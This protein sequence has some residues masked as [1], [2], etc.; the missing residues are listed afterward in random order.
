MTLEN[1]KNS[2]NRSR[3]LIATGIYPPDIG[4]PATYLPQFISFLES[5]DYNVKVVTFSDISNNDSKVFRISRKSNIIIRFLKYSFCLW[6]ESKDVDLI[7]LHDVSLVGI[8]LLLINFFKKKKYIIRIGGDN[9]WEQAYQKRLTKDKYFVFHSKSLPSLGLR[10]KKN[11]LKKLINDSKRV[12]V[13]SNFL[14]KA[15]EMYNISQ[16]KI[17]VISNAVDLDINKKESNLYL[18]IKSYQKEGSKIFFSTGRLVNWKNFDSLIKM[19][20]KVKDAKLF[21]AGDGPDKEKIT[22]GKLKRH[23]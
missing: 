23:K 13:P 3:V 17:E 18:K 9:I 19:F 14:K 1:K 2:V 12:I 5:K 15:L 6:K 16:D 8:S 4:G 21:I 22:N 20:E 11:I 10:I 7:Y